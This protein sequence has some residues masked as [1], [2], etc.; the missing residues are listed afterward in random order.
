MLLGTRVFLLSIIVAFAASG[1][2]PSTKDRPMGFT[3]LGPV[4]KFQESDVI[5]ASEQAV[6]V[7]RDALGLYGM[8]TLCTRDLRRLKA[9]R[10]AA[11]P[12]LF[13]DVC[14]SEYDG[15]GAVVQGPAKT[16]L[17]YYKLIVDS[18][19]PHGPKDTLYAKIGV[20]VPPT[21]RLPYSELTP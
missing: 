17:P 21:W 19:K 15:G 6:L 4:V 9:R 2:R 11:G 14:G 7:R 5:D 13:C 18:G 10:E 3:N 1:C 20:K 12:I 16:D 8:S